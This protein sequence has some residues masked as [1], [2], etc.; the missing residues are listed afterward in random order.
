MI[1]I[2]KIE[3][4]DIQ[5]EDVKEV[6]NLEKHIIINDIFSVNKYNGHSRE[7]LAIGEDYD[8]GFIQL[9]EI[10]PFIGSK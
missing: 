7:F 3:K 2:E 1:Y 5:I 9:N 8:D 4:L 10:I 6:E